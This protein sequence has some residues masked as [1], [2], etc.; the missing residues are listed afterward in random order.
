MSLDKGNDPFREGA[1]WVLGMCMLSTLGAVRI[2]G[3]VLGGVLTL[4]NFREDIELDG[5][6]H[7]REVEVE[8]RSKVESN[9]RMRCNRSKE[10]V[11]IGIGLSG[12]EGAVG[13]R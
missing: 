2:S 8:G 1:R 10:W 13:V 6:C 9:V 11:G 7:A 3:R 4:S 5:S 12:E